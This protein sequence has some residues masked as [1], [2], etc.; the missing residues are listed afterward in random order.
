[1]S[2]GRGTDFPFQC[3]GHPDFEGIYDFCFVPKA[4]KGKSENPVLNEQKCYGLDLREYEKG[5][6]HL[7]WLLD[8]YHHSKNKAKFFNS[9]FEKLAGTDTL[10]K[11]I[12]AGLSEEEIRQSWQKDLDAFKKIRKKYLIY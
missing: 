3:F 2:V 7:Q 4:I 5:G 8:A 6:L 11:Q 12:E 9:F 1:V 10:R